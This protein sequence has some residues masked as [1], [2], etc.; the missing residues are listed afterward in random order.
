VTAGLLLVAFGGITDRLIPLYAIGAF[1]TFT[2][3][4]TGMVVHWWREL[5]GKPH[6]R[7]RR[8][9]HGKLAI[10]AVGATATVIAL[11]VIVVAKFTQGGWITIVAIP[12]TMVLLKAIRRYYDNIDVQ[13]RDCGALDYHR[14]KPPIV[15]VTIREWNRLTRKALAFARELS[16]DV[17]AVHL[18]ALE[19][20][21]VK[22]DER[23]LR[24]QWAEAVE[25][26]A[27][28]HHA[29][30]PRLEFLTAPYRRIHA[31]FLKLIE[32]LEQKNPDRTIAVMIP[33]LVKRHWWEYLLSARRAARLRSA[34][35]EY[36]GPRVVVIGV[37]WYVTRPKIGEAMTAEEAKEPT[38]ARNVFGFHRHHPRRAGSH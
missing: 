33:E 9:L 28:S 27:R 7:K 3:S 22:G 20:P 1:L 12:C 6:S 35:L 38:H 14:G 17:T 18:A 26:P 24:D 15:L 37:P 19:G 34:V 5:S 25:K 29:K 8:W 11:V 32:E 2:M 36:G 16:T 13:L 31:P 4:Q 21:D 10:N 23:R 30:P